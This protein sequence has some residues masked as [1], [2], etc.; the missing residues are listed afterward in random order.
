MNPEKKITVIY[1]ARWYPHRYDPM[2]GLFIK[3]H[4]EASA[5]YCHT[6]VVY[7]HL[8]TESQAKNPGYNTEILVENGVP[9]IC[10]Y[11]K[12]SPIPLLGKLIN[13]INYIR[14]NFEGIRLLTTHTGKPDLFHVHILTRL[15]V[16]AWWYKLK[17]GTPY[18]ISEH[19]SRYLPLTGNFKGILRKS[20]TR[21]VAKK[22]SA[23]TT[24][25]DNLAKAMQ[26]HNIKNCRYIVMPNVVDISF[27]RF[28]RGYKP[29][30]KSVFVHVSCFEDRS[31]NISGILR[32]IAKLQDKTDNFLFKLIGEGI[33]RKKLTA[34]A[35]ELNID[36][37]KIEFTGLLTGRDL[38]R[39]MSTADMLVVFSNYENM[40]VVINESLTLGIPV[41]ATRVGGIPEVINERNGILINAGDE[42]KLLDNLEKVCRGEITFDMNLIQKEAILSWSTESIG[43]KLTDLYKD[44]V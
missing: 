33:D 34:Y 2:Y 39:E 23:I 35:E 5:Q 3:R 13:F 22:A 16:I 31:K 15:A 7:V 12:K 28:Y 20:V 14:H 41:I 40:P 42:D 32:V 26:S 43:K 21:M 11:Y 44:V 38:S 29:P 24:V 10:I 30:R 37:N 9:T 8:L 6:G 18:I 17:N 36:Q 1:L 25:T 4:A 19:W 27:T